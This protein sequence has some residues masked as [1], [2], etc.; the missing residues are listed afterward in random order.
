MY[1]V[2]YLVNTFNKRK[3]KSI[4]NIFLYDI[5]FPEIKEVLKDS[6]QN[7]DP[8][9]ALK[10]KNKYR[11]YYCLNFK[12]KGEVMK[13]I[14]ERLSEKKQKDNHEIHRIYLKDNKGS[15]NKFQETEKSYIESNQKHYT[16]N[17][18]DLKNNQKVINQIKEKNTK[19]IQGVLETYSQ[20]NEID[21]EE[22]FDNKS[23]Q[24]KELLNDNRKSKNKI[25]NQK[26][27]EIV[28]KPEKTD[29]SEKAK[30]DSP[31]F[32]VKQNKKIFVK[33]KL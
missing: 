21:V 3:D 26:S 18:I 15:E 25:V 10:G 27:K 19:R 16:L 9:K 28:S 11:K 5:F 32:L 31:S 30:F 23:F 17:K 4:Q 24:I 8:K 22:E 14:N 12:L 33:K 29:K 1:L 7:I 20:K 13:T 2:I 6:L